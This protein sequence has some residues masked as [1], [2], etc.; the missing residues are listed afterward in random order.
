MFSNNC[1]FAENSAPI[2]ITI[3]TRAVTSTTLNCFMLFF[4][5]SNF[6]RNLG[7]EGS[8][9]LNYT[10]TRFLI[11][12]NQNA[13]TRPG[14]PSCATYFST[15]RLAVKSNGTYYYTWERTAI[16]R[17]RCRYRR[18]QRILRV[19]RRYF[20]DDNDAEQRRNSASP[21]RSDI[22]PRNIA[23][24]LARLPFFTARFY[25][26]SRD[27]IAYQRSTASA[28]DTSGRA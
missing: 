16:V 14:R 13:K 11:A 26:S 3:K 12:P 9:A 4:R 6:T 19:H 17:R 24:L 22:D 1:K 7:T 18:R 5:I 10:Y 8:F 27:V 21:R 25:A 2:S 23:Y 20:D 28:A 15:A